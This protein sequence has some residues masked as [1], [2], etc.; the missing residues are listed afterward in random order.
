MAAME[1]KMILTEPWPFLR[2]GLHKVTRQM[3]LQM[4]PVEQENSDMLRLKEYQLS[5]ILIKPA[6]FIKKLSLLT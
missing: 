4:S 2:P 3:M 5:R 1:T 6:F